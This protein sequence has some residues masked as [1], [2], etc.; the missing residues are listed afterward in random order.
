MSD[1]TVDCQPPIQPTP[2]QQPVQPALQQAIQPTIL[3]P[4]VVAKMQEI[5]RKMEIK[6]PMSMGGGLGA[7]GEQCRTQIATELACRLLQVPF[8]RKSLLSTLNC[9]S[10]GSQKGSSGSKLVPAPTLAE[11]TKTLNAVKSALRIEFPQST[12]SVSELLSVRFG[13]HVRIAANQLLQQAA[14]GPT[15]T[16]ITSDATL[17]AAYF[18]ALKQKKISIDQAAIIQITSVESSAFRAAL[19]GLRLVSL[20]T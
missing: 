8:D 17:A 5:L 13:D 7:K 6:F 11:Y 9:G 2:L 16:T 18:M 12:T 3:Q 14:S 4:A 19:G 15:T 10:S 1:F 20:L